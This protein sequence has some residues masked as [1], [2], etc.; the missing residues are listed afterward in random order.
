MKLLQFQ[1]YV[2]IE[3]LNTFKFTLLFIYKVRNTILLNGY[4]DYINMARPTHVDYN[5]FN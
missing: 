4:V 1:N 5:L 3:L 2:H